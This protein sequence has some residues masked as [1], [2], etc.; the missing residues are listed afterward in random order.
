MRMIVL[1]PTSARD[2]LQPTT[3]N[4]L[5]PMLE[6]AVLVRKE[7]SPL[8]GGSGEEERKNSF[9]SFNWVVVVVVVAII[10]LYLVQ[11]GRI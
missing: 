5:L 9:S 1:F 2:I 10:K 6:N 3:V 11:P 4:A 8:L 7:S